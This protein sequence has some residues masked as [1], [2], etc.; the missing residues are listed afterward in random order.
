MRYCFKEKDVDKNKSSL[1]TLLIIIFILMFMKMQLY[2]DFGFVVDNKYQIFL[3]IVFLIASFVFFM[4]WISSSK[5]KTNCKFYIFLF[6]FF[7]SSCISVFLNLSTYNSFDQ[8]VS[9]CFWFFCISLFVAFSEHISKTQI[10]FVEK[11]IIVAFFVFSFV[12]IFAILSGNITETSANCVYFSILLM[13]IIFKIRNKTLLIFALLVAISDVLVSG[14]RAAFLCLLIALIVPLFVEACRKRKLTHIFTIVLLFVLLVFMYNFFV[15]YLDISVL[16][17]LE[18]ISKDGGSGRLD[19]FNSV[20]E[21]F[22][23]LPIWEKAFGCGYSSVS[24]NSKI[25][26]SAHNDFLE[27][28]YDYGYIGLTL[29]IFFAFSLLRS[30]IKSYKTNNEYAPL[31]LST[32]IIFVIMSLFSHLIIYPTYFVFLLLFFTVSSI[33]CE[34]KF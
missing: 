6:L 27:I 16:D 20:I 25:G 5:F 2:L 29:Y 15:P 18:D 34:K 11:I 22:S 26:T 24:I 10:A 19:I 33:S 23:N 4:H 21:E 9:H 1:S 13:P 12:Y 14:K 28:L 31:F 3:M 30:I 8:V 17:R 7:S 32:F